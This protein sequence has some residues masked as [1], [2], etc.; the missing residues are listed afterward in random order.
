MWYLQIRKHGNAMRNKAH[1][2]RY[3]KNKIVGQRRAEGGPIQSAVHAIGHYLL[4]LGRSRD[5]RKVGVYLD[6]G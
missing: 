4:I 1:T 2:L 3:S 5:P 6:I